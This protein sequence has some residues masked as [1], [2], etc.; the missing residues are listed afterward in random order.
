MLKSEQFFRDLIVIRKWRNFCMT[1]LALP[2]STF[3]A[4]RSYLRL[5]RLKIYLRLKIARYKLNFAAIMNRYQQKRKINNV[6]QFT[7]SVQIHNYSFNCYEEF[8]TENCIPTFRQPNIFCLVVKTGLNLF[9]YKYQTHQ[10][11]II[12]QIKMPSKYQK[13]HNLPCLHL[14]HF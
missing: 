7:T 4:K 10:T 9:Q 1:V 6:Y 14:K 12:I 13:R 11:N 2:A 8:E 5:R 3:I